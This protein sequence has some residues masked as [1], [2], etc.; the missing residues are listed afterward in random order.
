MAKRRRKKP[1]WKEIR[2]GVRKEGV[3]LFRFA[4]KEAGWPQAKKRYISKR[5]GKVVF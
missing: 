3:G 4:A 1:N 2:N 5:T